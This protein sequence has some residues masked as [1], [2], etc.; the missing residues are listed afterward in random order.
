MK[1]FILAVVTILTI[2]RVFDKA[3]ATTEAKKSKKIDGHE[4]S[5][6]NLVLTFP[7]YTLGVLKDDFIEAKRLKKIDDENSLNNIFAN[8]FAHINPGDSPGMGHL[9]VINKRFTNDFAPTNQGDSP[10]IG[11][12]G[13]ANTKFTNDFAPTNPGNSPGI[14]HPGIVN[15]QRFKHD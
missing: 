9:G 7:G 5:N 3:P 10:G 13:V 1:L 4:H 6:D 12:P 11:H 8:D 2:S 15:I 14:G